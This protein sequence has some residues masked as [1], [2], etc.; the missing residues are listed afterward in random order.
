MARS[1]GRSGGVGSGRSPEFE[2]LFGKRRHVRP[3]EGQHRPLER[4]LVVGG[5]FVVVAA[6]SLFIFDK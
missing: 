3:E 1:A 5:F 2:Q 4:L 6:V